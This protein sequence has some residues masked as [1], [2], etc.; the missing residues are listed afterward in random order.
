MTNL[1]SVSLGVK[2]T[3]FRQ[4]MDRF[5]FPRWK[6][7]WTFYPHAKLLKS[8]SRLTRDFWGQSWKFKNLEKNSPKIS[9]GGQVPQ[10]WNVSRSLGSTSPIPKLPPKIPWGR[11]YGGWKFELWSRFSKNWGV[12]RPKIWYFGKALG[13]GYKPWEFCGPKF[14]NKKVEVFGTLRPIGS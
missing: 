10:F 9:G 2:M 12:P 6:A 14:R 1:G 8:L 3:N 11:R 4:P 7:L 13:E 5:F